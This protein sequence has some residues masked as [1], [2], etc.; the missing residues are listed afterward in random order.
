MEIIYKDEKD[1]TK[2]NII[3]LFL[4]VDWQLSA[5]NPDKLYTALI[6]SPTVF[7]AWENNKLVGL[8][9]VLDDGILTASYIHYVLVNSN[10]QGKG[11]ASN[12]VK[13]IK[14]KY[15]DY[16]YIELMPDEKKNV[17]FYQKLGFNIVKEG[18][19]M[20]LCNPE[21]MKVKL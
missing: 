6:N 3:E 5:S 14:N 12:L 18:T 16:L 17:N 15:K 11:I 7:T 2:E 20:Q 10:Y 9:R 13:M 8:A 4:S 19:L 21:T 1:F